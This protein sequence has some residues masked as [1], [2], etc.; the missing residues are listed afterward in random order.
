MKLSFIPAILSICFFISCGGTSNNTD[1]G[2]ELPTLRITNLS[3][4]GQEMDFDPETTGIYELELTSDV[5]SASLSFDVSEDAERGQVYYSFNGV[6]QDEINGDDDGYELNVDL[7]EG[8][9]FIKLT[10]IDEDE[11]SAITYNFQLY[12]IYSTAS[13]SSLTLYE[14]PTATTVTDI[15]PSFESDTYSYDV[16]VPYDSC[17]VSAVTVA[18][19]SSSVIVVDDEEIDTGDGIYQN[20][21]VGRNFLDIYVFSESGDREERY[22][23]EIIR[24]EADADER[25]A[26]SNLKVLRVEELDLDFYCGVQNY[27][28]NINNNIHSL[29]LEL[30]PEVEGAS[31]W[32]DGVLIDTDEPVLI[33]IEDDS[34]AKSITVQSADTTSTTEYNVEFV[35]RSVNYTYVET[36]E[37]LAYALK[38]ARPNDYIEIAEG[39]YDVSTLP[40]SELDNRSLYIESSGS[41]LQPIIV[42]A[43]DEGE[44]VLSRTDDD[45]QAI[46]VFSGS[47]W[48]L[49][50]LEVSG[51]KNGLELNNAEYIMLSE[52]EFSDISESAIVNIG[53]SQNMIRLSRFEDEALG[54]SGASFIDLS[55]ASENIDIRQNTFVLNRSR[56]A[57]SIDETSVGTIIES[58]TFSHDEA[59]LSLNH[60][61]LTGNGGGGSIL[62][63][64]FD[65]SVQNISTPLLSFSGETVSADDAYYIY[66]NKLDIETTEENVV[67]VYAP[68]ALTYLQL[69]SEDSNSLSS[70]GGN[71]L[72]WSPPSYNIVLADDPEFCLSLYSDEDSD[73][74]SDSDE[75]V[76]VIDE[77]QDST[78]QSWTI[79][80]SGSAPYVKIK[81]DSIDDD[82]RYLSTLA[83]AYNYCGL[84]DDIPSVYL[85][86]DYNGFGQSWLLQ[87]SNYDLS[88]RTK[89]I[90]GYGLTLVDAQPDIED[91]VSICPSL[92]LSS[93]SFSLVPIQ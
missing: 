74:G 34:L 12:R 6:Y 29:T 8:I 62:Y 56:P 1:L 17:S 64:Q 85:D 58:N 35:R 65:F 18:S 40:E 27:A 61:L 38:N 48:Q 79:T 52:F 77:C 66:E 75:N 26:N 72:S 86:E 33:E 59:L 81:N 31:V 89:V 71:I 13:V 24:E 36:I 70:E 22:E 15:S 21:E 10:L 4:V 60:S 83:N 68:E 37:E 47:H 5:D 28:V 87:K 2:Y 53:G 41:A 82:Y 9:N 30:E 92:G 93:Q 78:E 25:E 90:N 3:I 39:E 73:Y 16:N 84:S 80:V 91:G 63:N 11:I 67:F 43:E 88:I 44:V 7:S 20:L 51:S 23:L 76:I 57:I 49:F 42:T 45:E 19:A 54:T 14:L 69:A 50:N 32:V 46:L 55:A